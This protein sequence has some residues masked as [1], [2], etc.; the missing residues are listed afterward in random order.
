[1]IYTLNTNLPV[2][3]E[4]LKKLM[5]SPTIIRVRKFDEDSYQDFSIKASEAT[6]SNQPIVP[7]VVDSYGG[8][9][10]ALLGMLDIMKNFKVPV[11][12]LV[13]TKAM[14]CGAVLL[15]SGTKD[16]RFAAPDAT[17]LV[18]QAASGDWGKLT[19]MKNSVAET[20]RLNDLLLDKLDTACGKKKG[21]WKKMLK[22]NENKDLYF[23]AE[24]AKK[25]GLI[26][27]IRT[28]ELE[29]NVKAEFKL[30]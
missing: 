27:H 9:V 25:L 20:E 2:N 21:F 4:E 24:E 7:V 26:D 8:Y 5:P 30:K 10:Y 23:S 1:M 13:Q 3:K 19:D 17:I 14:S 28:P 11:L 18:H 16:Y 6:Q 22:E 15:A 29:L 12:T